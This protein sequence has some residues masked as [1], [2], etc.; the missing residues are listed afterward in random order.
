V[1]L[2]NVDTTGASCPEVE[3]RDTTAETCDNRKSGKKVEVDIITNSNDEPTDLE[4]STGGNVI[5]VCPGQKVDW[6]VKNKRRLK[7]KIDFET[8]AFP[9]EGETKNN[10][11]SK[12]NI[13]TGWKQFVKLKKTRKRKN[14]STDE[15]ECL[16]YTI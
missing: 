4:V 3:K 10:R 2:T 1:V 12:G 7:F 11:D 16:K 9:D 5:W 13:W 6:N 15:D 8:E 14:E